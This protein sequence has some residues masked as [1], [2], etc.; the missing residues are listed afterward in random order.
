M[1]QE[2]LELFKTLT[3][4]QGAPGNEHPVR[5]F[6]RGELEKYADEMIQDNLGGV[7]GVKN[8]HGPRVMV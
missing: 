2:T 8:G 5:A 7:F 3:E 1:K 6:M 4:L